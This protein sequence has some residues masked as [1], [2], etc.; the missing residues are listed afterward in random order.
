MVTKNR[1][2]DD[3]KEICLKVR[4]D[5]GLRDKRDIVA[6]EG[7][8]WRLSCGVSGVVIFKQPLALLSKNFALSRKYLAD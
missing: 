1:F 5:P 6:W 4:K 7:G 3:K 2:L 8:V